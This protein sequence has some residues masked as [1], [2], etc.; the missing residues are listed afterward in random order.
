MLMITHACNLNCKYCYEKFKSDEKMSLDLAKKCINNEIAFVQDARNSYVDLSIEFMGG[1]PFLNFNLIKDVV[2]WLESQN[3]P[4]EWLSSSSTN[5][6]LFSEDCRKWMIQHRQSFVP[7]LSF[8]GTT[9]MQST[10]RGTKNVNNEIPFLVK[11]WPNQEIHMTLSKQTVGNLAEGVMQLERLGARTSVAIAQGEAWDYNDALLFLQQIR[12]LGQFYLDNPGK[13]PTT[14]LCRPLYEIGSTKLRQTK[15]CGAGTNMI[16]YDIDGEAY[17]CHMFTPLVCGKEASLKFRSGTF[18]CSQ[19]SDE[20]CDSCTIRHWCTTC[21]GFNNN[22]RGDISLRDNRFCH[23]MYA[24]AI[25]LCEFQLSYYDR[26]K[27]RISADDALQIQAAIL[28][29]DSL[30]N[31]KEVKE[32]AALCSSS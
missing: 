9:T 27:D 6:T 28:A 12:T 2:V 29:Y 24:E 25:G 26:F 10:N 20:R 15:F 1:E 17:P 30:K 31:L 14:F 18:P 4:F 7:C 21:C 13:V 11:N 22:I 5:G 3:L 19:F 32:L 8:D 23:M 16:T